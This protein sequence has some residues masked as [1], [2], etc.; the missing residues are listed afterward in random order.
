MFLTKFDVNRLPF[1][2]IVIFAAC[3]GLLGH[4]AFGHLAGGYV[5]ESVT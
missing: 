3:G 5:G 2:Y 1:L 4:A